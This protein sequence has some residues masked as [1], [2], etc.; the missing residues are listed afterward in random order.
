MIDPVP[1]LVGGGAAHSPEVVRQSLY[2]STSGAEG[3]SSVGALKVQA[4]ATP[5]ASVRVAPGGALL[6]N[7]YPGGAGQSYSA[8]NASQTSVPVTVTGSSGGRTDAVIL[9]V[10]DPA[11]E[12][13]P[14][15]DPN[16]FQYTRL[17]TVTAPAGITD[18]AQLSLAYPAILLARITIPAN[19]G[20]ITSAMITDLRKIANPRRKR[21]L[22][23]VA[24]KKAGTEELVSGGNVGEYWPNVGG[25]Q[26]IEIPVWATRC[27]IVGTWTGVFIPKNA[28]PWGDCWLE[29]GPWLGGSSNEKTTQTVGFNVLSGADEQR[30]TIMIADDVAIPAA[31]RGTAQPFVLKGSNRSGSVAGK[32]AKIDASSAVY[33]DLEFL[34]A[35]GEDA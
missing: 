8:R 11:Y 31:Y 3:I 23:T 7:R 19:T 10:L 20:T 4:Q 35:P 13:Q 27:R 6:N 21:D 28:N 1:W 22:R 18:I 29:F 30:V 26:S 5:G 9:R 14:P 24:I 34:E 32:R 25:V 17:V 16:N 12:G 2:D 33:M 15:A